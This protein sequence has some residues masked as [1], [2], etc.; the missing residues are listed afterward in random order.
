MYPVGTVMTNSDKTL[1]H[2]VWHQG[3]QYLCGSAAHLSVMATCSNM[4]DPVL[5]FQLPEMD[6]RLEKNRKLWVES[7]KT[8]TLPCTNYKSRQPQAGLELFWLKSAYA[9][10]CTAAGNQDDWH[11]SKLAGY[12]FLFVLQIYT[13]QSVWRTRPRAIFLEIRLWQLTLTLI[14][15]F[16]IIFPKFLELQNIK[17]VRALFW[18]CCSNH[19]ALNTLIDCDTET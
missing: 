13:H 16:W 12:H 15:Q 11:P 5:L 18:V 17:Y 19:Q 2:H 1:E 10:T 3:C 14:Y 4:A 9:T 8:S 6:V 7:Q